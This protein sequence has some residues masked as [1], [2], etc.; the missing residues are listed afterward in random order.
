MELIS[1]HETEGK[2]MRALVTDEDRGVQN[3]TWWHKNSFT[4][5]LIQN[6][7]TNKEILNTYLQT[8]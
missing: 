3:L 5:K 1:Q 6:A 2:W 8:I 7:N 4:Y